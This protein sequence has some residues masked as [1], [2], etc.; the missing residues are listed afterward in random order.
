M[1]ERKDVEQLIALVQQ[2]EYL[3]AMERYYAP[4]ASMQENL[5]EPR[6]GLPALLEHERRVLTMSE[7][8]A[9]RDVDFFT[10]DGDHAVIHWIFDFTLKNG[11]RFTLEEMAW[12]RWSGGKIVEERFFYD[13]VQ[14]TPR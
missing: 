14:R 6:R 9:A 13:P 4:D 3:A 5:Q 2:G 8:V 11:Q 10:V 12:Q 1:P 7:R